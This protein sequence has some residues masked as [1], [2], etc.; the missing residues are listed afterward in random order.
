MRIVVLTKNYGKN[1]TGATLATHT[2][3]H[4]WS[5]SSE[6]TE[7]I[8]LAQHLFEFD[9]DSKIHI[10]QYF[11]RFKIPAL[12]HQ[13]DNKSTI[14]YSDDHYGGF[15]A[16]AGV[17]YIHTYHGNWPDARWLNV[18]YFLKSF[19]FIPKYAKTLKSASKVVNVS[20]YMKKFTDRYNKNSVT[21]R[22][23]IDLSK[24][25]V[26]QKKENEKS[27]KC[28]MIGNVDLRKYG[29]LPTLVG[30]IQKNQ[31]DL[32]ID[33][34]G[35]IID[36]KLVNKLKRYK[37]I[38]LYGFVPFSEIDLSQYDF[39]LSTSTRENLPISIVEILKS[40]L[41]VLAI[42]TGGIPEV[43][44]QSSG[45]LLDVNNMKKN[46]EI[47]QQVIDGDVQFAFDNKTLDEFDWKKSS[48]KYLNIFKNLVNNNN[49]IL[50]KV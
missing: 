36:K 13:Y 6:V 31:L 5:K 3:I 49:N 10:V 4:F 34:Y 27:H 26:I 39:L 16:D 28:L 24:I 21:I 37:K 20:N 41:P 43:I 42:A 33:I 1:V 22:N 14:F 15:L 25:T 46:I 50:K 40:K 48:D 29:L 32:D 11:S 35:R 19:Y 30:E 45:R 18:E 47:I 17:K 44:D 8:V 12:L 9:A 23:G 2:F 38:K 7:I